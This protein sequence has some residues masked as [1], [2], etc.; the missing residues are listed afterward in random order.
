MQVERCG[1][2]RCVSRGDEVGFAIDAEQ[3]L[4]FARHLFVFE[5]VGAVSGLAV[6]TGFPG[7]CRMAPA[8]SAG[9]LTSGEKNTVLSTIGF[10][11][12]LPLVAGATVSKPR[13]CCTMNRRQ[14]FP[15][16]STT[17]AVCVQREFGHDASQD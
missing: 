15:F 4:F 1:A 8:T 14:Q 3:C 9:P 5:T 2:E 11:V 12:S 6:A 10:S 7:A 16:Q 13:P 17:A